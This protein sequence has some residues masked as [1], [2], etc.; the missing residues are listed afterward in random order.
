MKTTHN[1]TGICRILM[2]F[3]S[4]LAFGSVLYAQPHAGSNA[5]NKDGVFNWLEVFMATTEEAVKYVAPPN[6]VDEINEAME[7][8]E[9][10]ATNIEMDIRYVAPTVETAIL[11]EA[12]ERL[13]VL[14]SSIENEIRYRAPVEDQANAVEY[15][16]NDTNKKTDANS[17]ADEFLTYN[18]VS[19][20]K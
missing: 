16:D 1:H 12:F 6:E 18:A 7:N 3:C 5:N 2:V 11:T 10:M 19:E 17:N 14:A 15:A 13:D 4:A 9:L 20:K 8:L